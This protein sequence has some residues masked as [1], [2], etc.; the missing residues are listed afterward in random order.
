LFDEKLNKKMKST[1]IKEKHT[2]KSKS[3]FQKKSTRIILILLAVLILLRIALP[4]IVLSYANKTLSHMNGYYGHVEDIDIALYRGA[5]KIKNMYLNKID[6]LTQQKSDFFESAL[7]DLSVQWK[8]LF[9]GRLVGQLKFEDPKIKFTKDKVEPK[10]IKNDTADFRKLLDD[11]MPLEVNRFEITNGI[12]QFIDSTSKPMVDIQMDN[13]HVVAENLKSTKDT[14]LLPSTVDAT[15][16]VYRGKMTLQMKLDLLA[17]K[18][19]FD[20]NL[21]LKDTYLPDLNDFFKAYGK[22]D[23]NKGSFGL[24][25]EIASK[26]GKFVGY[27]KPL[28]KD[29]DILGA[30]DR[31]DNILQKIWEAF[32]GGA[33]QILKNQG[34]DQ[35]ATK[36]PIKG[37]FKDADA[38]IWIAVIEIFKNAFVQ[39]LQPSI[40]QEIDIASV[41][42]KSSETLAEKI[43]GEKPKD[44]EK[45]KGGFLKNIFNKNKNDSNDKKK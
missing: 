41:N 5:Y 2:T 20:M 17:K 27:V 18:P 3:F 4:Y 1:K 15:A 19:T 40:D 13:A 33:A 32:I 6:S 9:D 16:N 34:K 30:E 14:A 42:K 44:K 36:I 38:N 24:Y 29:L 25:S 45:K 26:Q 39:A 12:I 22:L 23:V 10:Q 7:I 11:F 35:V 8:A 37:T 21:E 31:K 28:I 43:T